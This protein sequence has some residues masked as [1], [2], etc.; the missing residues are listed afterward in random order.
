[1]H[2]TEKK[3]AK[4]NHL[5]WACR[6]II[7]ATAIVSIWAN[8]LHAGAFNFVTWG[9]AA[10]PPLVVLGGWELV[11][12]IPVRTDAPWYIKLVR[13][14]TTAAIAGGGAWLSYWHQNAAV[15]KYTNGDTQTAHVLPLLVDG[16]MI[17]A[18]VSVY[19]LNGHLLNLEASVNVRAATART[20]PPADQA[21]K[22]KKDTTDRERIAQILARSPELTVPEIAR[23]AGTKVPYTYNIVGQLRKAEAPAT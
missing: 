7:L 12:R 18:S 15:M 9:F 1:M 2:G 3:I 21:P 13:P 19:E 4:L 23:V 6:G 17:I 16:L 20:R 8:I 11:S 14:T 10:L 5:K 22:P